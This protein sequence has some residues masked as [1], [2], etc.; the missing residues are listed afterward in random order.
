MKLI[1]YLSF[2]LLAVA[3]AWFTIHY[4]HNRPSKYSEMFAH[5][6]EEEEEESG[7][8][9]PKR[10]QEVRDE[11]KMG[12][13]SAPSDWFYHQRAY[14]RSYID[15]AAYYRAY[16]SA[17]LQTAARATD[18]L[19]STWQLAGPVN[20]GGR[21][22]CIAIDPRNNNPVYAGAA[23]GGIWKSNG[24]FTNPQWTQIFS[25]AG[26]LS[27]GAIALAPSSPDTVWVG[28]GEANAAIDTYEGDGIW[29]STN[30]G[31]TWQ[32]RGL[33]SCA[34][35]GR[36]AVHPRRAGTVYVAA[37]GSRFRT[38]GQ[39]GLYKTTDA[40]ATW[41]RILTGPNDSTGCIDVC[42]DPHGADTV[43]A[44]MWQRMRGPYGSQFWGRGSTLKRSFNGGTTWTEILPVS[45]RNRNWC[46]IGVAASPAK[47][48]R[49]YCSVSDST[50]YMNSFWRSENYGTTWTQVD[51]STDLCSNFA[52]Y[53]G[54]INCS[55]TDSN[56]VYVDGVQLAMSTDAGRNWDYIGNWNGTYPDVHV[57]FHGHG[58]TPSGQRQVWG[59][60]GGIY[61]QNN[62][63]T[64]PV[65]ITTIPL[66]QFYAINSDPS[67]PE[68]LLGGAQDNGTNYTRDGGTSNWYQLFGGDGF[69]CNV[70]PRYPDSVYVE[71]Q[72]GMLAKVCA[73]TNNFYWRYAMDGIDTLD[74][75]AWCTPVV[76]DTNRNNTLYYGTYRLWRST[77]GGVSWNVIS[78]S[79]TGDQINSRYPCLVTISVS[80]ENSNIIWTGSDD[81]K[82]YYTS[83]NGTTWNNV[84]AGLPQR[85]V[86]RVVAGIDTPSIAYVTFSGFRWGES[87]AQV[88]R[89]TN[90]GATWSDIGSG[91]PDIPVNALVIDPLNTSH[92]YVGTDVSVYQSNNLGANWEIAAAGLPAVA[93]FDLILTTDRHLVAG[94]HGYSMYKIPLDSLVTGVRQASKPVPQNYAVGN[95]YPNPFN[96][97]TSL[98]L[99]LKQ[100][101]NVR[102]DVINVV[103]ETV[104]TL[105]NGR[106]N[107]GT[108]TLNWRPLQT[109]SGTYW[110]RIKIGDHLSTQ[111]IVFMK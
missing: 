22:T 69:C 49:L 9:K 17:V 71:Y 4:F 39:R 35:V 79:L 41:N 77:D 7:A 16:R 48:G 104:A 59:N 111:R 72:F 102:V 56:M 11:W 34:H 43:Y 66:T 2:G 85:S 51:I 28:T 10:E 63:T 81:G 89:T 68:R 87:I 91:L 78:P 21:I 82:V 106:M 108:R 42:L 94:T 20:V 8:P 12:P 62:A 80:P 97:Q 103:G 36:I 38:N 67:N 65:H 86:T 31:T 100:S 13:M 96:G 40:G 6:E 92:L 32:H 37:I 58:F 45:L 3:L 73:D 54:N 50:L 110:L 25:N 70:D 107:A 90:F 18:E 55:P 105:Q 23:F 33:D 30:A 88:Y 74:R 44:A 27:I 46:R 53:F 93:V 19:N 99:S 15:D 5:G 14:P 29:M 1:R 98:K 101:A 57:D 109:A 61:F 52:W 26:G 75:R 95:A 76:L 60:D 47:A 64:D 84:S 83:N 24:S